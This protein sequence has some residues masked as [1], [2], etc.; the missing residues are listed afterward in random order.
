M[1]AIVLWPALIALGRVRLRL[2][3]SDL[4]LKLVEVAIL[5]RSI[6][7]GEFRVGDQS[8]IRC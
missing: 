6:E 2:G 1:E 7:G 8:E 5:L 3:S 4:R